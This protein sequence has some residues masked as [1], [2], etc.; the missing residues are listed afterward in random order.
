[1]VAEKKTKITYRNEKIRHPLL[2][3]LPSIT[4]LLA[5]AGNV[6]PRAVSNHGAEE[7]GVEPGEGAAEAGN[8]TPA[9]SKVGVAGIVHL[10]GEAVPAI[11]QDAVARLGLDLLGVL[12]RL[13][14]QLGEGLASEHLATLLGAEAVLLAVACVPNPVDKQVAHVE[15]GQ[16]KAV[17][18]VLIRVV[19]GQE[20]GAVAVGERNAG[21]VPEDEHEAPLLVVHVPGGY[22]QL[23]A[24]GARVGVQVMRHD[25]KPDLTGHVAVTVPLAGGGTQG[26]QQ[27]NVPRQAHLEK[28]LEVE[29]AEHTRVELG[30]HE[31]IVDVV[32]GHA[33]GGTAS[34]G[35]DV[36]DNGD[37]EARDDGN[38]EQGTELVNDLVQGENAREVQD[39]GDGK[40]RVE[41][42]VGRAVVLEHLA[43]L[44][45][46]RLAVGGDTRHE[47]VEGTLEDEEGPVPQPRF[48]VGKRLGVDEIEQVGEK[49]TPT[50]AGF[51]AGNASIV[52]GRSNPHVPHEHGEEDHHG[53]S[54][55]RTAELEVARGV[56]LG[57]HTGLP[58]VNELLL[59][60]L[61]IEA[62][63]AAA[64]AGL[65]VQKRGV[66]DVGLLRGGVGRC[67]LHRFLCL[68]EV[69]VEL[70]GGL[71]VALPEGIV[72]RLAR[73]F[74]H[75]VLVGRGTRF[76][77]GGLWSLGLAAT[78][79]AACRGFHHALKEL[80]L[81][82][83]M[84]IGC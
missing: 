84:E 3:L 76:T 10:A 41:R 22:D 25:Q 53:G 36:G 35:R 26:E 4:V 7:N 63:A 39:T 31:E 78:S 52:L 59:P 20:D 29:D 64:A 73:G 65:S 79:V 56:D 58:A 8:Q 72:L 46:Q 21:K 1:M 61:T 34:K 43:A 80:L 75:K 55:I 40:G 77:V 30:A 5:A 74:G 24:L 44:V 6:T 17:P 67:G 42:D 23:L 18:A 45:R 66:L 69:L 33:V 16:G 15:S 51:A 14:G 11:H 50:L 68:V 9:D 19:V 81:S 32:A 37:D 13:P 71:Q 70:A 2:I 62:A 47:A 54:A 28:H 48:G 12:D 49:I 82:V 27:Q 57:V 38:R 60:G 83:R